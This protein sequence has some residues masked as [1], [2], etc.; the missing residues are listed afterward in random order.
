MWRSFCDQHFVSFIFIFNFQF[1][2][3]SLVS[4][5]DPDELPDGGTTK[6]TIVVVV[7]PPSFLR[8]TGPDLVV[9]GELK[10]FCLELEGVSRLLVDNDTLSVNETVVF[11]TNA[12]SAI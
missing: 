9:D 12:S 1:S 7:E 4:A 10:L 11:S 8:E 2:F 3:Y 6:P 5:T